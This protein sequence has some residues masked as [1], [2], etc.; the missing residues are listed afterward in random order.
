MHT[1]NH[2]RNP[3]PALRFADAKRKWLIFLAIFLTGMYLMTFV[4]HYFENN[5]IAN[6]DTCTLEKQ[7][8]THWLEGA[9]VVS[10]NQII[11]YVKPAGRMLEK[12]DEVLVKTAGANQQL[13]PIA[14]ISYDA[15]KNIMTMYFTIDPDDYKDGAQVIVSR[16]QKT[17]PY[18]CLAAKAV[19]KDEMGN[20]FVYL[21]KEKKSIL[22]IEPVCRMKYIDVY[23]EDG[24]YAAVDVKNS[25]ITADDL[26]V[27][28]A[29]RE[30]KDGSKIHLLDENER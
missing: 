14:K 8:L 20:Y 18:L 15:Q 29:D 24:V 28:H 17:N 27:Y 12:G 9:G 25:R 2:T 7:P 1:Q 23:L 30:I 13:L 26:F 5:G 11:A 22:G 3:R 21:V 19:H 6:I 10:G 4:Q 16:E